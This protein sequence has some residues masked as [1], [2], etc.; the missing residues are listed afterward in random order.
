MFDIR[1]NPP[2]FIRNNEQLFYYQD[3]HDK[4]KHAGV[5][6]KIQ[7]S[8]SLGMLAINLAILDKCNQNIL[9]DGMQI[10]MQGDR[11]LI[12][13]VNPAVSI[14]KEAQ[15]L[16]KHYLKE[17]QMS[18]KSRGTNAGFNINPLADDGFDQL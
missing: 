14:A 11:N 5:L 10:T 16:V 12:T 7:D 1:S 6:L 15:N 3:I 2:E 13:K 8:Y 17:F 9:D 18:P 4:L